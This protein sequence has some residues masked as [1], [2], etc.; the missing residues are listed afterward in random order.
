MLD[1]E[2]YANDYFSFMEKVN[3][4]GHSLNISTITLIG[5]LDTERI[6][7]EMLTKKLEGHSIYSIKVGNKKETTV[8]KRG[9]IKKSFFNQITLNYK[10][11]SK[12]SIKVFT[13]GRLHI[14]GLTS[15]I[16]CNKVSQEVVDVLNNLLSE[17]IKINSLKIGMINSN[18]SC[19]YNLYLR[20]EP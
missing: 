1:Q 6:D 2:K 11:L 3:L 14:T 18:F 15:Y 10:D 5:Y 12:K 9:K 13:N 16:E 4:N 17:N 19:N 8:T 20:Y 7:L